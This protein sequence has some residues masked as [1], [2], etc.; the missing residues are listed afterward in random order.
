MDDEM[1][2]KLIFSVWNWRDGSPFQKF[3]DPYHFHQFLETAFLENDEND[4]NRNQ[5]Q[6]FYHHLH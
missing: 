1:K 4:E 5:H 2:A 6:Y 3:R